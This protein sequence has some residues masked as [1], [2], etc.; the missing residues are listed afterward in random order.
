ME[1]F[2]KLTETLKDLIFTLLENFHSTLIGQFDN[3]VFAV[4]VHNVCQFMY[5]EMLNI[6]PMGGLLLDLNLYNLW[7]LMRNYKNKQK[8]AVANGNPCAA[9]APAITK[10]LIERILFAINRIFLTGPCSEVAVPK[11]FSVPL[12]KLLMDL[13]KKTSG[14]CKFSGSGRKQI[15]TLAEDLVFAYDALEKEQKLSA[16]V[17]L[18]FKLHFPFVDVQSLV[19]PIQELLTGGIPNLMHLNLNWLQHQVPKTT[20]NNTL[21]TN[22]LVRDASGFIRV[23]ICDLSPFL[24]E[25]EN[26]QFSFAPQQT[27]T[28]APTA[29]AQTPIQ[30]LGYPV[31]TI[32]TITPL[33][34]N[35]IQTTAV[36]NT[37]NTGTLQN[38]TFLPMILKTQQTP[39]FI[40]QPVKQIILTAESGKR[41]LISSESE[42]GNGAKSPRVSLD[43][44][45]RDP[46]PAVPATT[47]PDVSTTVDVGGLL[48]NEMM[49]VFA[50][51][52]NGDL[53][54]GG[55]TLAMNDPVFQRS[56]PAQ[57]L[58]PT[59]ITE[60]DGF[61]RLQPV[62][63]G[64]D[65]F[66]KLE[67]GPPLF[68]VTG[69]RREDSAGEGWDCE[70]LN[71]GHEPDVIDKQLME[72]LSGLFGNSQTL[73]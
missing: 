63:G 42:Q 73:S 69:E 7:T 61:Q 51:A 29:F 20:G 57:Q 12:F 32:Q 30:T 37:I 36:G 35:I 31:A 16:R 33:N 56:S 55:P 4:Q 19:R 41:K 22:P 40:Q 5:Q 26:A 6:G 71:L 48:R 67:D 49:P 17:R 62:E 66:L 43:P 65:D 25:A 15:M 9:A 21:E 28:V 18:F 68:P 44:N 59:A 11:A 50:E 52:G 10:F 45:N 47:A 8:A 46:P 27:I 24:T 39:Q 64:E 14:V 13:R 1:Q 2:L 58:D 23:E 34:P 53:R 38:V 72:V 3:N 60:E 54:T 70:L